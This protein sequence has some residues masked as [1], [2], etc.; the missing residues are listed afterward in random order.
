[1][2]SLREKIK[3][4][5]NYIRNS[6]MYFAYYHV[7]VRKNM[8]AVVSRDGEDVADNILCILKE[9]QKDKYEN[10]TIYMFLQ[11]RVLKEKK[12]ILENNGLS[13][14]R[15]TSSK[16]K[17]KFL[18]EVAGY[19]L[20]DS[21]LDCGYVKRSGQVVINTWHGTPFKVMGRSNPGERHTV[22]GVQKI[23]LASDY[24][25]YPNEFMKKIMIRDYMLENVCQAKCLC[26]G[27]P[28]NSQFFDSGAYEAQRAELGLKGQVITYMPTFRGTFHV[29]RN[30]EQIAALQDYLVTIEN[31]LRDDQTFFVKLHNYNMQKIDLSSFKK[32]K[33]F[34]KGCATYD[35]LAA[36]DIL[37]TDYSS[38]FFDFANTRRKIILFAYDE[39]SYFADRGVYFPFSDLPFAKVETVERLIEEINSPDSV[40]YPA[41]FEKFGYYDNFD[42]TR[43]VCQH[44]FKGV[45]SCVEESVP[46]NGKENI[47]IYAGSMAKNGITSA[48]FNFIS[49][50]DKNERNYIISF[51][52][53]EIEREPARI[54]LIPQDINYMPMAGAAA[55]TLGEHMAFRK[56]VRHDIPVDALQD[57]KVELPATVE[58][59]MRREWERFY[60]KARIHKIIRGRDYD[61]FPVL[62]FALS[63]KAEKGS[64]VQ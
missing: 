60:G 63:G 35:V 19:I 26:S 48:L 43:N 58:R 21:L 45:S 3:K 52:Q 8:I 9:L 49:K 20:T 62:L 30:K 32:V 38:V 28:R 27:Y 16:K 53:E 17:F 23:F 61:V 25:V 7:S 1:M 34:P 31:S 12:H 44:I 11:K 39:A 55:P 15:I 33:P 36:T 4:Y 18:L 51:N 29:R 6:V 57:A 13:Q 41:F 2:S 37:V 50:L 5:K 47:L 22:G 40:D 14:V 24:L 64:A 56:Y 46:Y 59:Y 42:A 54:N 10:Y